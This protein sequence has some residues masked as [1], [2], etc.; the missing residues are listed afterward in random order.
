MKEEIRT[1]VRISVIFALLVFVI[2]VFLEFEV[3]DSASYAVTGAV[4]FSA[5]FN[6]WIWKCPLLHSWL[7]PIPNLSG[8]WRCVIETTFEGKNKKIKANVF[9]KQTFTS[10]HVIMETKESK[11]ISKNGLLEINKDIGQTILTYVYENIPDV[12]IRDKSQIHFGAVRLEVKDKN[13][14]EGEYWSDRKTVGTLVFKRD[15]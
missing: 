12:Q 8:N 2:L 3:L 14:V 6:Y 1:L 15:E 7:I 4:A 9:I 5:L 11:S 10:I 13:C